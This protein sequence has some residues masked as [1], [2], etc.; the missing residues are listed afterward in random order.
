VKLLRI[1]IG[2]AITAIVWF[3]T[4]TL[5]HTSVL[6]A[7]TQSSSS[8]VIHV[9][10][11][12]GRPV[13]LAV[14]TV[15][16]DEP[17]EVATATSDTTGTCS[18]ADLRPGTYFVDARAQGFAAPKA[19]RVTIDAGGTRELTLT[20]TVGGFESHVVVTAS[21]AP[22][23]TDGV[24][25]SVSVVSSQEMAAR[26]V[27]T[28]GDAI[29]A[30]AGTRV[31]QI[32]GPGSQTS[33]Q[34]RGLRTQDTAVLIDGVPF[35]D[36]SATQGDATSFVSDLLLMNIDR[37]E[38]LRGSGADLY[39]SNAIAGAVNV[40]T[41]AG[42][43]S[44]TGEALMEGGGLGL[45]RSSGWFGSGLRNGKVT[46]S[47]GAAGFHVSDDSDGNDPAWNTSAAG[48]LTARVGRST[49]SALVQGTRAFTML[50]NSPASIGTSSSPPGAIF[51]ATPLS[52]DQLASYQSGTP[53][54]H[55]VLGPATFIPAVNDPDSS[56]R[57]DSSVALIQ[58]N[59][60][61]SGWF[62]YSAAY[63]RVATS[64]RY[65]NG[66]L[67][68]GFQPSGT[69]RSTFDGGIDAF[70]IRAHVQASGAQLV[71]VAYDL[72][73]E[74]FDTVDTPAN[75][76]ARSSVD[77][78]EV[79]QSVSVQDRL[80]LLNGALQ[81]SGGARVQLFSLRSP[82]LSPPTTAPYQGI[83]FQSPPNAYTG[84]GSAAYAISSS[85]TKL[86]AHA[87]SGYREPSLF[88]RFGT[89]FSTFGYTV[90][91]DPRLAS[92][93]SVGIDG[94]VDQAL[95]KHARISA[96]VFTTHLSHVIVFDGSGGI[97]S[98]SDPFGRSIGYRS[99][100]GGRASG[101]ELS[102]RAEPLKWLFLSGEYT[103]TTFSSSDGP[104]DPSLSY[105]LPRHQG[106][107]QATA[108]ISQ[109]LQTAALF[110]VASSYVAPLFDAVTFASRTFRFE[111]I[112]RLDL[113]GSY[114][115]PI[116]SS[117]RIR[118]FGRI[119]NVTDQMYFERG[120]RTPGRVAAVGFGVE[121]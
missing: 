58:L 79:S 11:G 109:R 44:P 78:T 3:H 89:A 60:Q 46:F 85:G 104:A 97:V 29:R 94:G 7:A 93:R 56:R 87:G 96:S 39:G 1:V 66:P 77:V 83:T 61:T 73:R 9:A 74:R 28:V 31:A 103:F 55:L 110:S 53:I 101:F 27:Y 64:R 48:R 47:A 21:N 35:R 98:S 76:A 119:D 22:E 20:L 86:R 111:G 50:N 65:E 92:E 116:G 13:D 25:K 49:V 45:I 33:I 4:S 70:N 23:R 121:F 62:G 117:Y 12:S 63:H 120:F 38:V 95:G 6:S 102:S 59:D 37:I 17:V 14:V 100:L 82:Q 5:F 2:W 16:A 19:A 91:G 68:V 107:L 67:G 18:F 90:Y 42:S 105:G 69:D 115:M 41:R 24:A 10:N 81:L 8:L 34:L 57:S 52:P 54:S 36:L 114:R 88:E 43:Q 40:I 112:N 118:F 84:D 75:A 15:Y 106:S 71:T 99:V 113:S 30:Q 32:G 26:D 80:A 108:Q 72:E 51:T